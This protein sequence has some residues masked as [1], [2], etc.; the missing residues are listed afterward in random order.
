VVLE[1]VSVAGIIA[2][3]AVFVMISGNVDLSVGGIATLS[4]VVLAL[5][6]EHH[7]P[8]LAFTAAMATGVGIGAVNAALV[9][10]CRINALIATLGM[11][12]ILPAVAL[13]GP[14]SIQLNGFTTIGL[15]KV[16]GIP[17]SVLILGG[18]FAAGA[19]ILRY[20]RYGRHVFAVGANREA[21]RLA[22]I[23]PGRIVAI[24]FVASGLCCGLAGIVQTAQ[25]GAANPYGNQLLVFYV[26]TA[27]VL[28]GSGLEGGTGSIF[29]AMVGLTLLGVIDNGLVLLNV[30]PQWGQIVRGALLLIAVGISGARRIWRT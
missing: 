15:G 5:V 23:K 14:N 27:V 30:A 9:T 4:G 1:N 21:A 29:G 8:V 2:V 26:L 11:Y 28:G 7:S 25:L 6:A 19:A 24:A 3:P 20:T 10:V 22:G 18:V 17:A 13:L 16:V 12:I